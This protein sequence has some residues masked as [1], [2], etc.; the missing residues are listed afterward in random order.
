MRKPPTMK[1]ERFEHGMQVLERMGF[2]PDAWMVVAVP[3]GWQ[4]VA[5]PPLD[6]EALAAARQ[7]RER[8][9]EEEFARLIGE[10]AASS[11]PIARA[12]A[13]EWV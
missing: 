10:L 9:Q 11:D 13:E 7:Q 1:F 2:D 12:L 4:I 6:H 3:G 5:R 8:Q